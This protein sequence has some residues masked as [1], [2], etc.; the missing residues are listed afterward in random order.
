MR[1][2]PERRPSRLPQPEPGAPRVRV[3]AGS[4]LNEKVAFLRSPLAYPVRPQTVE[5]IETHMS[6]VFL[7][8]DTVYKLKK[9]ARHPYLDFS[10]VQARL[11]NCER[12]VLL[13]RRLARDVYRRV[14]PLTL[15]SDNAL[16]LGGSGSAV[17]WLV[18]MR[19]LPAHRMLDA[20][21]R[22]GSVGAGD[23][24][25]L[26]RVL[27][28]F[29]RS[30]TPV[31]TSPAQ[32]RMGFRHGVRANRGE[33]VRPRFGLDAARVDRLSRALFVF[34]AR[35]GGLLERRSREGRIVDAHGDL[36]PEHVCLLREPVV[37]DCLEFN[38]QFR[39]LDPLD[40]LA[41]FA[42]ECERLG[43]PAVGTEV[44]RR[45]IAESGDDPGNELLAFYKAYRA[46]LRAKI[47]I[48]HI[49]DHELRDT[50]RWRARA[51]DYLGLAESYVRGW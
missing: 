26:A 8:G 6:W 29:Y 14:V 23:I 50:E 27:G 44:L 11:L 24:R 7:A 36:R 10:T 49:A 4:T 28:R 43:G 22:D 48:W 40:E 41:Y 5:A 13:N 18:E 47:A 38:R 51:R 34:I 42:M 32:Y 45:Y 31:A 17:D 16:Q 39:L 35:H 2:S 3:P 37:I 9:P 21:I 30:A 15:R 25:R 19:R 33:L 20:A 46:C 1:A 12:E